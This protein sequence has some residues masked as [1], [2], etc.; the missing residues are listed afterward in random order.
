MIEQHEEI[1]LRY[2][3][4]LMEK[5]T[6]LGFK[7]VGGD[8]YG[9][10]WDAER[11]AAGGYFDPFTGRLDE[12]KV[13]ASRLRAFG[14]MQDHLAVTAVM[15]PRIILH[16][17]PLHAGGAE[18]D[19]IRESVTPGKSKLGALFDRRLNYGG[20]LSA[21]SL[22]VSIIDPAGDLAF[23]GIGGIQLMEHISAGGGRLP[24]AQ[25][26]IFADPANDAR[27]VDIALSSLSPTAREGRSD[28]SGSAV[29]ETIR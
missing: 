4:V 21:I 26:E 16:C 25:S 17:A 29:L 6:Q 20:S 18:W 23:N 15:I 22:E 5:L 19:G 10:S 12:S 24:L 28:C 9:R 3:E 27:A 14:S 13:K 8:D 1:R 11:V 7:V 2:R